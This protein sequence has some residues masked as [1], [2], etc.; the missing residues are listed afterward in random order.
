MRSKSIVLPCTVLILWSPLSPDAEERRLSRQD[1]IRI[2]LEENPEVVAAQKEWEAAKARVIQASALPDP[3]LELEYE[4]LADLT[5]LGNFGER[6]FGVTQSLEFPLKWWRR[7]CAAQQAARGIRLSVLEATRQGV[8]LRVKTA[9]DRVLLNRRRLEYD[10]ENLELIQ[11]FLRKA[12]L[13]LEAGDVPPVDVMRAEVEAGRATNRLTQRRSDLSAAR[14]A[15]NTLLGRDTEAS[16]EPADEL[17]YEPVSVGSVSDLKALALNRRP[18]LVGG[19][20]AVAS[21]RSTQGVARAALIPDLS[22]GVF[23]QTLD[24]PSGKEDFWR[25][26]IG[27]ALPLWGAA[28]QRGELAE[29]K[30]V[31]ERAA[32]E[33]DRMRFRAQLEIEE[34]YLQL[35]NAEEQVRLFQAKIM[36]A[37]ERTFEVASR[38]Y[39]EGKASYLDVLEAQRALI[40][41]REEFVGSLFNYRTALAQLEW[42]AGGS[43]SE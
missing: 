34:A 6:S 38:S 27:L 15:L 22:I 24:A 28:R 21:A 20:W 10:H 7:R 32:A 9:Y 17:I 41:V 36:G 42:A 37:A 14:A 12:Q 40:E 43:L 35:T 11:R 13:R 8:T 4:E 30:A 18:E 5:G 31:A 1:A 3:E 39:Q 25:V 33:K 29:A 19:D 2:A 26:R 16:S 23:R